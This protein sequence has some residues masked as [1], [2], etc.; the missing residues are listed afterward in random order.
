[1]KL[2]NE[3]NDQ[4]IQNSFEINDNITNLIK[5]EISI[6]NQD[7]INFN[8]MS[9]ITKKNLVEMIKEIKFNIFYGNE[10]IEACEKVGSKL[11]IN[12]ID[13][14]ETYK[15]YEIQLINNFNKIKKGDNNILDI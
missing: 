11:S 1:M 7:I 12:V 3:Y 2:R 9:F 13:K 14:V 8:D 6:F 5:K 10:I 15:K 4:Y